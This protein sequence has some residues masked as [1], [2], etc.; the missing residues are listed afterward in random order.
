MATLMF[1]RPSFTTGPG[2]SEVPNATAAPSTTHVAAASTVSEAPRVQVLAVA[3]GALVL[4]ALAAFLIRDNLRD[5][6]ALALGAGAFA[7]FY[8]AAQAEERL[9]EP[10]TH[11]ILPTE[12]KKAAADTAKKNAMTATDKA[13]ALT[14]AQLAANGTAELKRTTAERSILFWAVASVIGIGLSIWLGLY[15][16]AAVLSA[17]AAEGF[18]R[19]LDVIATGLVIGGGSKALH[20]LIGRTQ[21]P[22][23]DGTAAQE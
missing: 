21:K 11:F 9:L 13:T 19:W 2:D 18:P 14:E 6:L 1:E 3:Y 16:F 20:E 7:L 8:V 5:P 4:A 15:F 22:K 23:S 17:E 12:Q 10:F